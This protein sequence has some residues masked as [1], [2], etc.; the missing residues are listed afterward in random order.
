MEKEKNKMIINRAKIK[1]GIPEILIGVLSILF[2]IGIRVWFPVCEVMG[3]TT[4]PCHWAGEMLKALSILFLTLSLAH[5]VIPNGAAK[6]GVDVSLTGLSVLTLN[7]PG[8]IIRTCGNADMACRKS[9]HPWT[10]AFCVVMI[11]LVL[12]DCVLYFSLRS[13][14]KHKRNK[15]GEKE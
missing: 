10:I 7:I 12:A 3:D 9:T 5:A 8:N 2:M 1:I 15:V 4:M 6:I 13:K 14:E 11:V